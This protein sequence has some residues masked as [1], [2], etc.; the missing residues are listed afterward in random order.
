MKLL[1]AAVDRDDPRPVWFSNWGTNDGTTSSLQ[2]ALD[3]VLKERGP[4]GYARFKDRLRLCSDDLF[5][6][7]TTEL[8]RR[9][10]CGSTPSSRTWTAGDGT[11]GSAR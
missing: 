10:S 11:T 1:I 2:R 4:D 6:E 7:H 8:S 9:G 5:G 3:R